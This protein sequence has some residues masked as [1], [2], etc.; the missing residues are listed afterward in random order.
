MK[1]R[2]RRGHRIDASAR[3][4][5]PYPALKPGCYGRDV[6][7]AWYCCA[8]RKREVFIVCLESHTVTEHEDGTISVSP[9]IMFS[10]GKSVRWHGRLE[11]G[12][13]REMELP[14]SRAAQEA[15]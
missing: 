4:L 13:W 6:D 3:H 8:P 5:F 14:D 15:A 9:S 10:N 12:M 11:R 1:H 2:A 7:G